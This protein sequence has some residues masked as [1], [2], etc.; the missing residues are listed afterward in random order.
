[1]DVSGSHPGFGTLQLGGLQLDIQIF[2]A[3]VCS[4]K[5][6]HGGAGGVVPKDWAGHH[7]QVIFKVFFSCLI[8]VTVGIAVCASMFSSNDIW[9][10]LLLFLRDNE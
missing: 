10:L 1:M 2:C 3:L 8:I 7:C 5:N 9:L 4:I 6:G